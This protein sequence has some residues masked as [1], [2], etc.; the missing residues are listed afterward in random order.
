MQPVIAGF[1][2][3][4]DRVGLVQRGIR[5]L[6]PAITDDEEDGLARSGHEEKG[7]TIAARLCA[8]KA[9]VPGGGGGLHPIHVRGSKKSSPCRYWQQACFGKRR[10]IHSGNHELRKRPVIEDK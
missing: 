8:R 9:K 5:I 1:L 10:A 7:P 4:G 6:A 2:R 3:E